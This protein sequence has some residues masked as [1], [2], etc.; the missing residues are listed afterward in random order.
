MTRVG[1]DISLLTPT[2]AVGVIHGDLDLEVVPNEGGAV[3]FSE[4]RTAVLPI[5]VPGFI[6]SLAVEHVSPPVAGATRLLL[7]LADIT[8]AT[9]ADAL[10]VAEYFEKGFGLYFDAH[11][12]T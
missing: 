11:E 7:S 8:V 4:P 5:A 9:R 1:I 2:S 12:P 6:P 3:S 10:K